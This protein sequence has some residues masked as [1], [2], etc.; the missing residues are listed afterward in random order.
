MNS[1]GSTYVD[2]YIHKWT[3]GNTVGYRVRINRHDC[4]VNE[5][6]E[7]LEKAVAFRDETLR[8]CELARIEKIK[9]QTNVKE[10]P[11]NLI[12]ALEFNIDSTIEH[13]IERYDY[14]ASHYLTEREHN[15]IQERYK[16]QKTLEEIGKAWLITRERARQLLVKA[17]RKTK[18]HQRYFELGEYAN[19]QRKAQEEYQ[20]YIEAKKKEW[21]YESA[22]AYIAEY[23]A[24]YQK[25]DAYKLAQSID[26]LD[27]SVRTYNCLAR[28]GIRTIAELLE[29]D[30]EDLMKLRN[31]GRK[32][33]R[34]IIKKM[35]EAGYP[36][37]EAD[38]QP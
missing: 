20:A 37:K 4:K 16:Y 8:L 35:E 32:S 1:W 27:F 18:R 30:T 10:W 3:K 7:T 19:L 13:F 9:E 31:L 26:D 25:S 2:K 15:I 34:E 29:R 22:K 12:E 24:E 33:L 17:L 36:I 14:I 5:R 6:F 38:E 28:A 11:Y 23:E 21:D